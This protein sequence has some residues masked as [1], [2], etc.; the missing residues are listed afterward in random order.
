MRAMDMDMD[1]SESDGAIEIGG[2]LVGFVGLGEGGFI[3]TSDGPAEVG[4]T[5]GADV[6]SFDEIDEGAS[7]GQS[8]G[9]GPLV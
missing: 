5:N 7:G 1:S 8:L 9:I 6:G 4:A 2:N 3:G